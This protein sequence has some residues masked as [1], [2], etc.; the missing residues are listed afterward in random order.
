MRLAWNILTT[1]AARLVLLALALFSSIILARILGPEGRG[2]FALVLLLPEL[3]ATFGLLG[4]EQANV[5]YA[6]LEPRGRGALVWHS[7]AI[8]GVVGGIIA[9][10]GVSFFVLRGPGSHALLHGPL[11]LYILPLLT[12][13]SALVT[14]YWGAILRGMN[15]IFLMNAVEVGT[16][17]GSLLLILVLVWWLR[18]GVA[19]AVSAE[20]LVSAGTVVLM[21]GL[22]RHVGTWGR[23]SF[24]W[25]LWRRIRRFA[26]PAYCGGITSYLNYRADQFIIAALLPPEQLGFYAIAVGL[27]ERLWILTGAVAHA[28]LPHLANS[29]ERDPA[30]S[31][32]VA[33]HVMIWT[34]G[35]CLLVFALADV[36][37]R[38]MYSSA[39]VEA[40]SPLRWMLPGIFI[41]TA[42][43]VLVAEI[44]A[45]EKIHY[46]VWVGIIT[47]L[48]N[49]VGNFLLV[50]RMGI[51]GAAL[52][53]SI[54][55]ALL[56]LI[57]TWYYLRETHVQWTALLPS[58]SDLLPYT[59]L[60][61]HFLDV[62]SP[63]KG[64]IR[65]V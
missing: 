46:T 61:H 63:A 6:G 18:L 8:A 35:A 3:G 36:M 31:A 15:R 54:S 55:Y 16:K 60:W 42:G 44:L 49:I 33:R 25:P 45:R 1:L 58:R 43:K 27:A 12:V 62:V 11:W 9:V 17:G 5:V 19:G 47:V 20:T 53:S 56:S 10:A 7:T 29:T 30:L 13:P 52:A 59:V 40:V 34:G 38:V 64:I 39:F 4:F 14:A 28:L 48:V 65:G 41:A 24:D 32:V 37:V 51:S 26:L 22:L 21:V 50:P 57:L 23:P 2:V